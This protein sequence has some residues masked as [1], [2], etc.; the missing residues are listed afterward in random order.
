MIEEESQSPLLQLPVT[1][2]QMSIEELEMRIERLRQEILD[3]EAVLAA[4]RSHRSAADRLF[5]GRA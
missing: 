2:D 5:S 1:M 3:C 4:K